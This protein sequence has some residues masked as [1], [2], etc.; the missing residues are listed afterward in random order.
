MWTEQNILRISIA[1]TIVVSAVGIIFG[2]L[3]GSFAIVFDGVYSLADASMSILALIVA[4]LIT[5]YT[6]SATPGRLRE[7]FTVGFWHLEP[8]V[9]GLNGILLMGV[10]VYALINAIGSLLTGGRP[11]RFDYAIIY[12]A[13]TLVV[14]IMMAIVDRRANRAIGSEF[15][16]LDGTA[17]LMSAGITA[18]LLIAFC[19]GYA[20]DGT[21]L[22]WISPYIDP[23]VLALICLV[24]IPMPI[25]TVRRALS[26]ILLITPEG[27]K[28]HVDQIAADVVKR[29]GFL[30]Y[31]A[32]VARVGRSRQVE[33]Y[34]IV[35]HGLPARTI[36][37]WDALRDEIGDQL[38]D[39]GPN[40]WLTIAFTADKAWAD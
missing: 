17:W 12:A 33:L 30:S 14:C 24:I 23:A 2:L 5:S 18:A 38:G 31:R 8:I 29:Y 20:I 25:G 28:T 19:I 36:E 27:L 26:D 34:F 35:P 39:D 15:L 11:L 9:L 10:S 4:G 7:R 13:F 22:G 37:E 1:A 21:A 40:W 32:Y 16:A 6:A 3:S